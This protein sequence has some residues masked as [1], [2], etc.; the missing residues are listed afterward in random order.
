MIYVCHEPEFVGRMP[1][2]SEIQLQPGPPACLAEK[3]LAEHGNVALRIPT[4]ERGVDNTIGPEW[5]LVEGGTVLV[6]AAQ[7]GFYMVPLERDAEGWFV[8]CG[9]DVVRVMWS[10]KRGRWVVERIPE[11]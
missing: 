7:V 2:R 8:R 6:R 11:T 1:V 4:S 9:K 3:E 5:T 10:E